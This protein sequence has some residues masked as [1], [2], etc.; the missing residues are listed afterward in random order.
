MQGKN[1]ESYAPL[2][3]LEI[4]NSEK[5]K[6]VNYHREL[7]LSNAI[8]KVSYEMA[9]IKYTREYFV[10]APDKVM[11]IK[12]TADQKGALNFDINLKSLLQSNKQQQSKQLR[13]ILK[14]NSTAKL[15]QMIS[16]RNRKES[17]WF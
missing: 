14:R 1:S 2:G 13:T 8:S 4:N 12:L 3:T 9:G 11:I 15:S 10:S 16:V 17:A 7:D 6:A 5:G